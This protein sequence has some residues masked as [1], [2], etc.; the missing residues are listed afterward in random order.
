MSE[1][2]DP[3]EDL[4]ERIAGEITLSDDPGATLRKWRTDFGVSQT[5]LADHLDV[6]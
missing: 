1:A 5:D 2:T 6:S 4:A 3:R